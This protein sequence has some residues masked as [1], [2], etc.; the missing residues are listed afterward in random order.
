MAD[1]NVTLGTVFTADASILITTLTQ[2]KKAFID[3]STVSK[4][5]TTELRKSAKEADAYSKNNE[6]V[7]KSLAVVTKSQKEMASS[8]KASGVAS[9][10][11]NE[12]IS[13][14]TEVN[15]KLSVSITSVVAARA[16]DLIIHRKLEAQ[17]QNTSSL[18]LKLANGYKKLALE[19]QKGAISTQNAHKQYQILDTQLKTLSASEQKLVNTL[20]TSAT[21]MKS[22]AIEAASL[23]KHT[24]ELAASN[25]KLQSSISLLMPAYSA[26]TTSITGIA[27]A[28]AKDLVTHRKL[29]A[30]NQNTSA[31]ILKLAGS[32][33]ALEQGMQA[34][35]ISTQAAYKQY[36]ILNT[37]L[38]TLSISEQQLVTTLRS[39]TTVEQQH[40]AAL[41]GGVSVLQITAKTY[42]DLLQ[43]AKAHAAQRKTSISAAQQEVT[44]NKNL[45][46][47]LT[48]VAAARAKDLITH[49]QAQAQSQGAASAVLKLAG[50]YKAL[51][52]AIDKGSI[53]TQKAHIQYKNLNSQLRTLTTTEQK[54]ISTFRKGN[55]TLK[56]VAASTTK[57]ASATKAYTGVMA[58]LGRSFKT[59]ASYMVAGRAIMLF[60]TALRN[61]VIEIAN[62][63][64]ALHNLQAITGATDADI[65]GMKISLIDLAQTT[66][67]STKELAE[68]MVLLGQAGFD[69]HEAIAAIDSVATLASATLSGLESTSQLL[70]TTIRAFGL[71]AIEAGRV[72]DV[73]ANA[74][75]KSKLTIDKLNTSFNYVGVS[76]SQAGL[77]IE[78]TAATMMVLANN[79]LRASTIGTGFRQVLSRLIAPNKKLQE[80][81]KEQ[82]IELSKVNPAI[83]GYAGSLKALSEVLWDTEADMVDMGKAFSLFGLRGAQA[84]AVIVKSYV[85]GQFQ[86]ALEKVKELGTAEKMAAEQSEGLAFKFKNLK[87]TIGTLALAVG[88]AGLLGVFKGLVDVLKVGFL[89]VANAINT[90]IGRMV[91]SFV[92]L[93]T[94]VSGL[95]LAFKALAAT[96]IGKTI[97]GLAFKFH[98]LVL[99]QNTAAAS[100]TALSFSFAKLTASM[101]A[102]TPFA[103]IAGLAAIVVGIKY[104]LAANDRLIESRQKEITAL[105]TNISKYDLYIGALE[106]LKK[107]QEAGKNVTAEQAQVIARLRKEYPKLTATIDLTTAS[108]DDYVV[109]MKKAR[110]TDTTSKIKKLVD[111]YDAQGKKI[112]ETREAWELYAWT[113]DDIKQKTK[114]VSDLTD[115]QTLSINKLASIL[116]KEGKALGLTGTAL[117]DYVRAQ[118]L[119]L[120]GEEEFADVIK[121]YVIAAL[122]KKAKRMKEMEKDHKSYAEIIIEN[123]NKEVESIKLISEAEKQALADYKNTMEEKNKAYASG[124]AGVGEHLQAE[125]DARKAFYITLEKERGKHLARIR[126]ME[127]TSDVEL[128]AAQKAYFAAQKQLKKFEMQEYQISFDTKRAI[129]DKAYAEDTI[130]KEQHAQKMLVI[131]KEEAAAKIKVAQDTLN[132]LLSAT[133]QNYDKIKKARETLAK[134]EVAYATLNTETLKAHSAEVLQIEMERISVEQM[135]EMDHLAALQSMRSTAN[136]EQVDD[137]DVTMQKIND[138]QEQYMETQTL[139]I[140]ASYKER[141]DALDVSL[142][143]GVVKQAQ[144]NTQRLALD[145]TYWNAVIS[146]T[147]AQLA[148]LDAANQQ[149][150]QLYIE[151]TKQREEAITKLVA[152]EKK[153]ADDAIENWKRIGDEGLAAYELALSKLDAQYGESQRK[154]KKY[155]SAQKALFEEYMN[156]LI[157]SQQRLIAAMG[158]GG[159]SVLELMQAEKAL[160][161]LQNQLRD[162]F[163]VTTNSLNTQNNMIDDAGVKWDVWAAKIGLTVQQLKNMKPAA[164]T[165]GVAGAAAAK[166][167]YQDWKKY[168]EQVNMTVSEVLAAVKKIQL[169]VKKAEAALER[170]SMGPMDTSKQYTAIGGDE[171]FEGKFGNAFEKTKTELQELNVLMRQYQKVRQTGW[172]QYNNNLIKYK[173]SITQA[174]LDIDAAERALITETRLDGQLEQ[175]KA[176]LRM[177]VERKNAHKDMIA[178]LISKKDELLAKMAAVVEA[179]KQINQ[180]ILDQERDIGRETMTGTEIYADDQKNVDA[181]LS[182]AKQAYMKDDYETAKF[183]LNEALVANTQFNKQYIDITANGS[184]QVVANEQQI[185]DT[186]LSFLMDIKNLNNDIAD[187]ASKKIETEIVINDTQLQDA[188][189]MLQEINVE[190]D[191]IINALSVDLGIEVNLDADDALAVIAEL[192]LPTSSTHTINI[193]TNGDITGDTGETRQGFAGGGVIPGTG[194]GDTVPA[195][196]TPGEY[197]MRKDMVKKFGLNIFEAL[198]RGLLPFPKYNLGGLVTRWSVLDSNN[199]KEEKIKELQEKIDSARNFLANSVDLRSDTKFRYAWESRFTTHYIGEERLKRQEELE[200]NLRALHAL[201]YSTMHMAKGGVVPGVGTGDTVP[202]MLTP[203]EVVLPVPVLQS[204]RIAEFLASLKQNIQIPKLNIPVQKFAAGGIVQK[205]SDTVN[206]NFMFGEKQYLVSAEASVGSALI[207]ELSTMAMVSE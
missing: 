39:A 22:V 3:F 101:T 168:A 183:Y 6:K 155:L 106:K 144:Y 195:M 5:V 131:D 34:G 117:T 2:I 65:I 18:I 173:R 26:L 145:T 92:L 50:S 47:S 172:E 178:S 148:T 28:R 174:L 14:Q 75:N 110:S 187:A 193:E 79:G 10:S 64:Q 160:V 120:K 176:Q 186:R 27:A 76:A 45:Q 125:L 128:A 185:R 87:D 12:K 143:S 58:A 166:M 151:V 25:T 123:N 133:V 146:K 179:Q 15:T 59:M 89:A 107:E 165:A 150:T 191:T 204:G 13:K 41:K 149:H 85:G 96:T 68:G 116:I 171:Y 109:A 36:Q 202:A 199:D 43:K 161:D 95:V 189:A 137:F 35:T 139:H 48:A 82:S 11:L 201:S 60:T 74:V 167:S 40:T 51:D 134:K 100:T 63:D 1:K 61:G 72:S 93:T 30:Q 62:F 102:W 157:A 194:T 24:S 119:A 159:A 169:E 83:V 190:I 69:A 135:A 52:A 130:N 132:T 55:I 198:N 21:A 70:T 31:L 138:L 67:F 73:M 175:H 158:A 80:A 126:I 177:Y 104:V 192:K 188:Y 19:V 205:S 42:A 84:A 17:N 163:E 136:Q 20:S 98:T 91:T 38:K 49:R 180:S 115:E 112:K 86:T 127:D 8:M 23:Y 33:K 7:A 181:A 9:S 108:I 71:E 164:D 114:E 88:D 121:N 118:A 113:Q 141:S 16:K 203:G 94:A 196:L 122:D 44:A 53:S 140:I 182:K 152:A 206:L 200:E 103:I 147:T 37:Q 56:D 4:E 97:T 162:G 184:K 78:H 153:G 54:L 154:S 111:L 77:S 156:G 105:E 46:G 170:S 197:V 81:F 32:Y 29:E 142:K 90:D 57:V 99:A 129:A 124:S 66:K 207:E